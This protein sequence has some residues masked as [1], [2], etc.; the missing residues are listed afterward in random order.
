MQETGSLPKTTPAAASY[1]PDGDAEYQYGFGNEF[2]S[3]AMPGALP[4]GQNSPQRPPLG[5][6]SELISGTTFSAPRSLNRRSYVFRIRPSV[7]ERDFERRDCGD[8][9]TAPLDVAPYPGALRWSPFA[10][11]ASPT[12][13]IDGLFT[14]CGNGSAKLQIGMAIHVF[15]ANAAMERRV[16]A[17]ADAE[18]LVLP[19]LGA[20]RVMTEFGL[21][22]AAPGE[23]VLLPRG[24]KFRIDPIDGYARGFVAE[25][26]GQPFGLP[27]LGLLGS[28]GLANAIDF[29]VPVAAF[30]DSNEQVEYVHK[31]AGQ[32]WTT[33]L[34]HSPFDVVAWRGNLAPSK[35]D[36][37][38]FVAMGSATTDHPDPSIFCAL[39]SPSS[40][41]SGANVDFMIL[42][43]RWVSAEGTF[44]PPGFHRNCV[45][46]FL[47][48]I[49]GKHD[50]KGSNFVP[51]AASLHNNWVP[52]G[53]DIPTFEAARSA[54]LAPTKLEDTL[55]F[56]F[57]TRYPLELTSAAFDSEARQRDYPSC[58]DGFRKRFPEG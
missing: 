29:H 30:E 36:M 49:S 14:L 8:F 15:R 17:N 50:S 58:W 22:E 1:R 34:G 23:V 40:N 38:R 4:H 37:R 24:M 32:L 18:M 5:L 41:V 21:I 55:V 42:P 53:P 12:D 52:H 54:E 47:G 20:I 43:P 51:G 19:Q 3:E 26:Y 44:R 10:E 2:A 25:N 6:V 11:P 39:S 48:I 46:E 31:F 56:M 28:H 13:F 7:L 33:V 9:R 35:F 45:A 27:D 16:F 57:E